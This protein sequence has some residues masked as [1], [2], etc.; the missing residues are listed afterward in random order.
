MDRK[1]QL[2]QSRGSWR[3][4]AVSARAEARQLRK[5]KRRLG[6]ERDRYK[7]IAQSA[8]AEL[9][10]ERERMSAVPAVQTKE[11]LVYLAL[12]LFRDASEGRHIIPGACGRII[13]G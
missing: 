6:N 1:H 7:E 11:D 8:I 10:E 3:S 5:D 2:L 12:K 4:K 13:P 9:R